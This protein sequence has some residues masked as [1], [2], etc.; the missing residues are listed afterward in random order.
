MRRRLVTATVLCCLVASAAA[1]AQDPIHLDT[2]LFSRQEVPA[3]SGFA[4]GNFESDL[5]G[6]LTSLDWELT[7]AGVESGVT[8]AHIHIG[9]MGV[10]G[11][12]MVF[13]CSNLGNG[14]T[15]TPACPTNGGTLTG[16]FTAANIVGPAGQ[17]VEAGNFFEF[18]RALR[19]GVAYVNVHSV[20]YPG[21]ELRGQ[22]KVNPDHEP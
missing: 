6:D 13:F 5:S 4:T 12:I 21:G 11:G 2:R 15:G 7:Y 16:T 8:Q 22:V 20:T 19:Q 17:G 1:F 3:I 10:N 9:Q 14:P 18:Q